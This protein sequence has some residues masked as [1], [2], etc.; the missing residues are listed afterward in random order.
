MP[1]EMASDQKRAEMT[2]ELGLYIARL[3]LRAATLRMELCDAARS[4][5]ASEAGTSSSSTQLLER[6]IESIPPGLSPQPRHDFPLFAQQFAAGHADS[7]PP[8]LP[9]ARLDV[10]ET[11]P[12]NQ[13]PWLFEELEQISQVEDAG[14]L[15]SAKMEEL[16]ESALKPQGQWSVDLTHAD[17]P[18]RRVLRAI[19]FFNRVYIVGQ[20][21]TSFGFRFIPGT[22]DPHYMGIDSAERHVFEIHRKDGTVCHLHYNRLGDMDKPCVLPRGASMHVTDPDIPQGLPWPTWAESSS[23]P[24]QGFPPGLQQMSLPGD[25]F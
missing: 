8:R 15:A 9:S 24:S 11:L 16:R 23:E 21:I 10:V 1:P 4:T 6:P 5:A 20:G 25:A 2:L 7:E 12:A 18:W 13:G 22:A 14:M 19:S 3:E 17:W